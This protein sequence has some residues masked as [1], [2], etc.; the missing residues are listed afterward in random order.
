MQLHALF[1]YASL[2]ATAPA[3]HGKLQ[4]HDSMPTRAAGT[5]DGS[6]QFGTN[7][8]IR[9]GGWDGTSAGTGTLQVSCD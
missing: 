1:G 6:A 3:A 7:H 9:L 4:T 5:A 2:A 8:L